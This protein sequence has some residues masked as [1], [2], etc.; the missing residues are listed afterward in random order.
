MHCPACSGTLVSLDAGGISVDACRD[1][2]GGLWFDRSE[3]RAMDEPAE[4][5]ETLLGLHAVPGAEIEIYRRRN[6]PRCPETFMMQHYSSILHEVTVDECPG[7]GG[8]WLDGGELKRLRAEFTSEEDRHK[9]NTA[10]TFRSDLD[11]QLARERM[12]HAVIRG[13]ARTLMYRIWG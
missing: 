7:C 12:H 5:A 3:L 1:G 9:A 2:C 11:E 6:C 10:L 8:Y 4:P 13:V